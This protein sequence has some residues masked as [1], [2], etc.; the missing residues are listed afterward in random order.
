MGIDSSPRPM[1]R[2]TVM[3]NS[4]DHAHHHSLATEVL[5]RARRAHLAGATLLHA[6]E[7]QGRSG[8]LHRQHLFAE[9]VP[10]A[11]LIIDDTTKVDEFLAEIRTVLDDSLVVLD[12]VTAFR[13]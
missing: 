2:L 11:I 3:L 9:D 8:T 6:A 4:R 5:S 13:A 1:R 7:G 10:L 12:D